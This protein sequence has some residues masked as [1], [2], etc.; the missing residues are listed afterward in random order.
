M[1]LTFYMLLYMQ[2]SVRAQDTNDMGYVCCSLGCEGFM[3]R[4][5]FWRNLQEEVMADLQSF[6]PWSNIICC[7]CSPSLH[8]SCRSTAPS[9]KECAHS[10]QN[11]SK[12]RVRKE[13]PQE[14]LLSKL[15]LKETEIRSDCSRPDPIRFLLSPTVETL[16]SPFQDLN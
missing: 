16:G 13:G 7:P 6:L 2:V 14:T 10:W 11:Q 5:D 9:F 8:L 4:N 3:F 15:L 12:S 1:I